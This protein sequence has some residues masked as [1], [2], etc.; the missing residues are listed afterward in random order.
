MPHVVQRQRM[1]HPSPRC[2]RHY[3]K[4]ANRLPANEMVWVLG[5]PLIR[6]GPLMTPSLG[7]RCKS[8]GG[9]HEGELGKEAEQGVW[10]ESLGGDSSTVGNI[11]GDNMGTVDATCW[12]GLISSFTCPRLWAQRAGEALPGVASS[13]SSSHLDRSLLNGAQS[14]R[15]SPEDQAEPT[16]LHVNWLGHRPV[17]YLWLQADLL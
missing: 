4:A 16:R 14:P 10:Q 3:P 12:H 15:T 7:P 9:A 6:A 5:V 13:S 1:T 17:L 11:G 8:R 2:C